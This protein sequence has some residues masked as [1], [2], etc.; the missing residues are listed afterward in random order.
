MNNSDNGVCLSILI[1]VIYAIACIGSDM[2]AWYWIE[3]DSFGGAILFLIAWGGLGYIAKILAG[4][5]IAGITS[6]ME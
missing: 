3:P 2:M 6:K 5:L 4:L 1:I